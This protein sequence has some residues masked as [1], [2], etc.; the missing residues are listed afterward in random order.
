[1]YWCFNQISWWIMP[2]VGISS[3]R[4]SDK[5][6]RLSASIGAAIN[7]RACRRPHFC[8]AKCYLH[9]FH[10]LLYIEWSPHL[11]PTLTYHFDILSGILSIWHMFWHSFWWWWWSWLLMIIPMVMMMMIIII[12]YYY[13]HLLLFLFSIIMIWYQWYVYIIVSIKS[14]FHAIFTMSFMSHV[15]VTPPRASRAP[16]NAASW[17]RRCWALRMVGWSWAAKWWKMFM[18]IGWKEWPM[19][20]S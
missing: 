2:P 10:K 13:Y 7:V 16:P 4:V 14:H 15:R 18:E 5:R 1:M 20:N 17:L 6:A 8:S 9:R 11:I 19:L 12:I 3:G